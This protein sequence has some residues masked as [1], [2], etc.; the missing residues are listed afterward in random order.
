MVQTLRGH[1]AP[2]CLVRDP[3]HDFRPVPNDDRDYPANA[4]WSRRFLQGDMLPPEPD[5]IPPAV[6][7]VSAEAE[8][9]EAASS[10]S[11]VKRRS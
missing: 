9:G 5:Q 10:G 4:Y 7:E 3:E 2:G 11:S 8:A 1:P 6:A